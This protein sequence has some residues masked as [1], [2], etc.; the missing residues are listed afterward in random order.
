[1]AGLSFDDLIPQAAPVAAPDVQP[2]GPNGVPRI[3]VTP[4]SPF[5]DA[6]SGIESGGNYKS[7]GPVTGDG[8]RAFGKYQVMGKN[9]GPWTKEVF[10]KPLSIGQFMSNPEIQDAVFQH[11]FGDYARK[12]GPEGASRAWFAGEGGMNDPN[13]RDVL[14]TS[15]ADYGRKFMAGLNGPAMAFAGEP[16]ARSDPSN[17]MAFAQ[18]APQPA[19]P[20]ASF[21]PKAQNATPVPAGLSFDDLVPQQSSEPPISFGDLVQPGSPAPSQSPQTTT[22]QAFGRGAAQGATFN[23][24]DELRGLMEA[25]GLNPNDPASLSALAQGAA[26]YFSG[27]KGAANTYDATVA[28]ERGIDQAAQQ[29]HPIAST[30]GSLGGALALPLGAALNGATLPARI[31]RGI[32]VGAGTGAAYG[33]GEGTTPEDRAAQAL[34]GGGLGGLVGGLAAPVVETGAKI[35][36]TALSKPISVIRSAINPEAAAS[37]AVGR[38]FQDATRTDPG[39]VSRLNPNELTPSGPQT[40]LDTL[41]GQGRDLARSAANL[42]GEARDTLNASLNDR[43]VAQTGRFIDWLNKTFNFPNAH[44]QQEAIDQVERTVNRA[45][46]RKA[47][48]EGDKPIWS[49]ELERLAGSPAV[50]NGVKAAVRNGKDRAVTQ[51]FGGFR[52]P[53]TVTDDGRLVFN[54]GPNGAPTYPNLQFWDYARREISD[55]ASAARRAGRNEEA[56]RLGSIASALNS[57]L[58]RL[59][60]SYKQARAGAA[61]FFGAENALEAGQNFVGQ[62]FAIPAVRAA[63]G[64][65]TPTE[66]KLFQDGFISRYIETIN[67]IP[68]RADVVRRIYN[69]PEA[70]EKIKL[71]VGPQRAAELEAMLRVEGIMQS[72][73]RAVQGNSSTVQQYAQLGLASA[74]GGAI[75]AGSGSAL[76]YDPTMS[77][78]VGALTAAGKRG[79]DRRVAEHIARMLVSKDPNVLN[80]GISMIARSQKLMAALRSADAASVRIGSNQIPAGA[81]V[82]QLPAPSRADD[83]QPT[84]PRPPGQ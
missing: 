46:Y 72:G 69:S 47:Y 65:M 44:A 21:Q 75:G 1:M 38:A 67:K 63:L 76:G 61:G 10:G 9:I 13:R 27:D 43:Y 82:L 29:Q 15:V 26:R 41:G 8:D 7:V 16:D 5:A 31:G 52:V 66:R 30:A 57:E 80:R 56:Q 39:A 32:A 62:N 24:Y 58:D 36:G 83:E 2:L 51:G 49:P 3:T 70:R 84:V 23:F 45:A 6:I 48:Q 40:V 73:L 19:S 33:A 14:G 18:E 42:S 78:I 54:R 20:A 74:A 71:V 77:G 81:P 53:F 68:D 17:L 60:P 55:A 12:Y 37:R 11:K 34:V 64:K 4:Q 28:R 35:V 22:P 79:V 25:G 50:E 59:V